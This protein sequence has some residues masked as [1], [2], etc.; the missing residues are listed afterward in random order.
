MD[1]RLEEFLAAR[2]ARWELVPHP[3]AVTAQ[4]QAGATHTPGRSMAKVL[5]VKDRDDFAMVV[6]PASCLVDLHRLGGLIGHGH[7]RLATVEEIRRRIPNCMP[8]AI[9]PFGHLYGMPTFVDRMI[10]DARAVTIPAGDPGT[11]VRMSTREY[12]RLVEPHI[13]DFA[14]PEALVLTGAVAGNRRTWRRAS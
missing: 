1:Q 10:A 13:G 5:I 2:G 9:P 7:V 8:G 11:S 6:V 14:V 4:E 3:S 12:C